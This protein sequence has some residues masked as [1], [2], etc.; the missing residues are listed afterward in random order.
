MSAGYW[1]TLSTLQA[2]GTAIT[3]AA[4]T[5]MTVGS[6]QARFTLPPN[7]IKNIGDQFRMVATGIISC[8][9][10]TPGTARFDLGFGANVVMDTQAI[11]L[12]VVAKTSVGFALVMIGTVR[13]VGIAANIH[14]QGTW[15]SEAGIGAP[16]AAVGGNAGFTVPYN[17]AAPGV[18]A[19]FDSTVANLIDFFFTQTVATGSCTL[20]DFNLSFCTATGY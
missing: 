14:W 9:V 1:E 16:L 6:T 4:R 12:N 5:S 17:T 18:G 10:T 13:A 3:A 20:N 8:A 7:K 11:N 19:N 2:Q 15:I